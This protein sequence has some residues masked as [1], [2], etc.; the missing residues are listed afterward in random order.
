MRRKLF[1]YGLNEVMLAGVED[2]VRRNRLNA[3]ADRLLLSLN[4]AEYVAF[5]EEQLVVHSSR[6]H[7][8]CCDYTLPGRTDG[9]KRPADERDNSHFSSPKTHI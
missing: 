3:F 9:E 6:P 1:H 4:G 7:P 5:A 2:L 8:D